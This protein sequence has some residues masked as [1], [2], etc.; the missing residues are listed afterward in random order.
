[1]INKSNSGAVVIYQSLEFLNI[2]M[3]QV[4][5]H[6]GKIHVIAVTLF[7]NV[8]S[9]TLERSNMFVTLEA[10]IVAKILFKITF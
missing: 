2:L 8:C 3:F 9:F 4:E 1:M 10:W 5:P 6:L 7:S